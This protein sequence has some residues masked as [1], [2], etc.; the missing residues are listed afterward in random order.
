MSTEQKEEARVGFSLTVPATTWQRLLKKAG[1]QHWTVYLNS[2]IERE[3][4]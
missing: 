4:K 3:C 1:K 2:M